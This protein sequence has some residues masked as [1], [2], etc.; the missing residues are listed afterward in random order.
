[1]LDFVGEELC[2]QVLGLVGNVIPARIR[3]GELADSYLLHDVLVTRPVEG[4]HA[5]QNDVEDDTARP[6]VTF[7]IV[8]LVQDLRGDVV[9]CTKLLIE[10][11]I[12]V[13]A[14][15]CAKI[16]DLNLIEILVLLQKDVLG[17]QV[18]KI[19]HQGSKD[20]LLFVPP[21]RAEFKTTLEE[22]VLIRLI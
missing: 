12:W 21:F 13:E 5:G 6:D 9:G 16:N 3:E 18:S 10:P 2:D 15:G 14:E 8:A 7:L 11:L 1:M 4:W 20:M 19:T 22:I 17:L